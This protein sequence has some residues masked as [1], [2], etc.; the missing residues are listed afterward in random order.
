LL[1]Y[2]ARRLGYLLMTVVLVSAAVFAL[3]HS[4]PGGPFEIVNS[5]QP[6]PDFA[7]ANIQRKYGL[8][9]PVWQ[10]YLLWIWAVLHGDFGIPFESPTETVAGLIGRAWPVTFRIGALTVAIAY[11]FGLGLGIVAA[12][13][14]NTWI[15]AALTFVATLGITLPN[16][17][18]GYLLVELFSVQL[19][20]LPTGGCCEPN[21]YLMPVIAYALTP[22]ALVARYTRTNMLEVMQ[23]EYVTMARARGLPEWRVVRR[24]ILRTAL[25]PLITVLG[26]MIPDL[27]TGSLFIEA[28]FAIP[29]LGSYF[30][31]ASL[32]R[33]YPTIMALV[34]LVCVVWGIL[35]LISDI[36]YALVDPRVR[37]EGLH[38]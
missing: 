2:I 4:V 20:W 14:Q 5:H 22:M 17:V 12:I 26:P 11:V 30:T 3:M 24:Y 13:K 37:I 9:K 15:D 28:T 16:F 36:A 7:F 25:I 35:Y 34:L 38:R 1:A 23:M 33:D 8:D 27:L 21:Q 32:Q 31:T 6:L 29:G 19:H 10:Q 18:V